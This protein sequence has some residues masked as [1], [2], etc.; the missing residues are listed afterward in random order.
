VATVPASPE[1]IRRA[2]KIL[3]AGGLVAFPTETVYGLGA[4]ARSAPACAKIFAVKRRPHFDPLIVHAFDEGALAEICDFHDVRAERLAAAFWPGPLTL[5]LPKTKAI[6]DIVTSGL[7][8]IAVRVPA[9]PVARALLAESQL[10]IAAPSANPFGYVSPTEAEHVERALGGE[11]DLV[12]DGGGCTVGV[13]STIVDL[14]GERPALLRPGGISAERIEEIVGE[15]LREDNVAAPKA[16]GQLERHYAPRTRLLL[17]PAG[18]VLVRDGERSGL[19]AFRD[20]P[21]ELRA[22][23]AA[24][25]VLSPAGDLAEAAVRLFAAL[26]RLDGAGL[27]VIYAER[28][29]AEGLGVA[30]LDRLRRAAAARG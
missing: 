8:T 18:T 16:P 29:P 3:R 24:V 28:V 21:A 1:T 19:L 4:D 27:D 20:P 25:E 30:I 14:S 26:H 17:V 2:A 22:R 10:P 7:P 6:P 15:L 23:C 5:V 9:H 12:L 11:I 13:E